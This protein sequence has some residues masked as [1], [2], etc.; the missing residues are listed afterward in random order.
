MLKKERQQ[1]ILKRV[2][3]QGSAITIELTKELG[4]SEDTIRK[5]FQELSRSGKVIRIH[6]GIL[7][8]DSSKID[9]SL[10]ESQQ[11]T[12][13]KILAAHAVEY[14]TDKKVLFIDAGTTNLRLA[15][16]LPKS[17]TGTVITNAPSIALTL[18]SYPNINVVILGGLIDKTSRIVIG[19]NAVNQ[20]GT[21][22][23]E[24]CVLGVG[25]ISVE[26]G[27]TYPSQE[28]AI[29]KKTA[30]IH[31]KYVLAIATKEKLDHVSTFFCCPISELDYLITNETNEAVLKSFSN[32]GVQVISIPTL[33]ESQPNS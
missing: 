29:L 28:E 12:A 20:L 16:Q 21:L 7:K 27:I 8:M 26:H 18:C 14:V 24:C 19:T 6:G 23:L 25:A 22:N 10:R 31:S 9:Y 3:E 30:I 5:D 32:A 2:N 15:E 17:Y 13:K 11:P 4:V 33:E 1:Y